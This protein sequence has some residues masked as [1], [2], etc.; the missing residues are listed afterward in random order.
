[1]PLKDTQT[2]PVSSVSTPE[3]M[4]HMNQAPQ[5]HSRPRKWLKR[6]FLIIALVL[7]VVAASPYLFA[8]GLLISL[9]DSNQDHLWQD[10]FWNELWNLPQ[11][12]TLAPTPD[13]GSGEIFT[14]GTLTFNSPLA[15]TSISEVL[16]SDEGTK[17]VA[18]NKD[19]GIFYNNPPNTDVASTI[20]MLSDDGTSTIMDSEG[21]PESEYQLWLAVS[22]ITPGTVFSSPT[23]TFKNIGLLQTKAYIVSPIP[24]LVSHTQYI[25]SISQLGSGSAIGSVN[26][27]DK[28]GNDIFEITSKGLTQGELDALISSIQVA[29][30]SVSY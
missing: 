19:F 20:I 28:N 14:V 13:L 2:T 18:G 21:N 1:M 16:P 12:H 30:T 11:D 24:L 8:F 7:I 6:L 9:K 3:G 27:F 17:F 5:N 15:S 29:T 10:D 25:D 22:S 23:Q 26:I 4:D